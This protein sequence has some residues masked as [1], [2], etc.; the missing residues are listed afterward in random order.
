MVNELSCCAEEGN[1]AQRGQE[2]SLKGRNGKIMIDPGFLQLT[3]GPLL[4][5]FT[6]SSLCLQ[7]DCDTFYG[8]KVIN[9]NPLRA[10]IRSTNVYIPPVCHVLSNG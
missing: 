2:S 6:D 8:T 4:L 10:F 9:N 3:L 5:N 7:G 1:E